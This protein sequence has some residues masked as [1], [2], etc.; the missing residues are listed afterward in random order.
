VTSSAVP[1]PTNFLLFRGDSE[2]FTLTVAFPSTAASKDL[3]DYGLTL[4]AKNS[5]DDANPAAVF[6]KTVGSGITVISPL[7]AG[8]EIGTEDTENLACPPPLYVTDLKYDLELL[9]ISGAE[10]PFTV[11]WGTMSFQADV[12][13][14]A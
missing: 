7:V 13:R 6:T 3:A 2:S 8:V 12:T 11:V 5:Y 9:A 10:R 4:T 14:N 1:P